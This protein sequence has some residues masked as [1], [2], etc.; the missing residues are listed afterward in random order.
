MLTSAFIIAFLL[1]CLI[2]TALSN[3]T[4]LKT[5]QSL[6]QELSE[7]K[8]QLSEL[9]Q[10]YTDQQEQFM[11]VFK[12]KIETQLGAKPQWDSKQHQY[13]L[14]MTGEVYN[15]GYGMA[16]NTKLIVK[17]FTTNSTTPILFVQNLGNIDV[18]S[19]EGIRHAFYVG[20]KIDRWEIIAN[21]TEAK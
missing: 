9:Q 19:Y 18:Y 16:F 17:V 4:E 10:N 8:Q 11:Q 12:P 13:Y 5:A 6:Q 15:R 1:V 14:W 20:G 2:G 3:V 7:T 21:C